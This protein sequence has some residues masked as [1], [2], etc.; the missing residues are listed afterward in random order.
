MFNQYGIY[1]IPSILLSALQIL[2]HLMLLT[3]IKVYTIYLR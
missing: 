2:I 3:D 1:Y